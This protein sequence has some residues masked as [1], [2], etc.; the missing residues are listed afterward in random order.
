MSLIEFA[1]Q[2][3]EIKLYYK[4]V[5]TDS[6]QSQ[7]VVLNDK[8]GEIEF[9]KQEEF[10]KQKQENKEEITAEDRE[11]E[12]LTTQWKVLSWGEQNKITKRAEKYTPAG[13]KDI[14]YVE[15]RDLRIKTCLQGWDLKDAKGNLI[16]VTPE[17]ID[18]IPPKIIFELIERYDVFTEGTEEGQEKN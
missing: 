14:D 6:G 11:I 5:K 10:I 17:T 8:D 7:F 3:I 15:F 18:M 12:V 2:Q 16:P 1:N 13:V 4:R 9:N